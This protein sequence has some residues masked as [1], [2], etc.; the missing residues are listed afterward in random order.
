MAAQIVF[1]A[2]AGVLGLFSVYSLW[3]PK[4][5]FKVGDSCAFDWKQGFHTAQLPTEDSKSGAS[6]AQA[7][8]G[9][10]SAKDC[11][12]DAAAGTVNPQSEEST[13]PGASD[14]SDGHEEHGV[15]LTAVHVGAVQGGEGSS[16]PL[17]SLD[18]EATDQPEAFGAGAGAGAATIDAAD[19][20][21]QS[22]GS[23]DSIVN[24][25]A[26]AGAGEP[27]QQVSVASEGSANTEASVSK[28]SSSD[29]DTVAAATGAVPSL[30]QQLCTT[31]WFAQAVYAVASYQAFA[32]YLGTVHLQLEWLVTG[33]VGS[34][35]GSA[36][37]SR[38]V[39]PTV[40][41]YA[42]IFGWVAPGMC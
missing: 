28:H 9:V 13:E 26:A 2:Y 23:V 5:I 31:D 40:I 34:V 4:T 8:A 24:A 33:S 20:S 30:L 32:F 15:E 17:P 36:T 42:Q 19:S 35:S 39:N 25:L 38:V 12:S 41:T 1:G 7:A 10:F 21:L 18:D 27:E 37:E 22:A 11:E 3:L 6:E 14:C 29:G 16:A